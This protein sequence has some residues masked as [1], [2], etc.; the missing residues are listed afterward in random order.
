MAFQYM[1]RSTSG[2]R[3]GAM[4]LCSKFISVCRLSCRR[5]IKTCPMGWQEKNDYCGQNITVP[6]AWATDDGK[7]HFRLVVKSYKTL[8]A[9]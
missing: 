6:L 7:F 1:S 9:C 4:I 5:Q 8:S 3:G 2:F